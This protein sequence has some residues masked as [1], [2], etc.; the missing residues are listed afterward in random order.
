MGTRKNGRAR[1]RHTCLPRGPPFSL[2]PTT[3][4]RLL[5]RLYEIFLTGIVLSKHQ[6]W[7]FRASFNISKFSKRVCPH[8]PLAARAFDFRVVSLWL[9]TSR[10][11]SNLCTVALSPQI[12]LLRFFRRGGGGCTRLDFSIL[13]LWTVWGLSD[14]R[15]H[16]QVRVVCLKAISVIQCQRFYNCQVN[17]YPY[18]EKIGYIGIALPHWP[19]PRFVKVLKQWF[20]ALF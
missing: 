15:N 3:S 1:R 19:G 6:K 4:K 7:R 10:F 18:E 5:R 16:Y 20:A 13:K 2:S 12:P 14:P 11:F 8:T 17:W 9:T